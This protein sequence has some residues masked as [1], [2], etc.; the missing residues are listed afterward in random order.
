MIKLTTQSKA[1]WMFFKLFVLFQIRCSVPPSTPSIQSDHSHQV[2]PDE[3]GIRL[4]PSLV[5]IDEAI[6]ELRSQGHA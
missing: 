2:I 6:D 4:S 3:R 1:N 5:K